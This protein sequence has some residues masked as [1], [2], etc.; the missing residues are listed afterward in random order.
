MQRLTN[1]GGAFRRRTE[2]EVWA[3]IE[4]GSMLIP[5]CGCRIWLGAATKNGYGQVQIN[6]KKIYLHRL[7]YERRKGYIPDGMNVCHTCDIPACINEDHLWLGTFQQNHEDKV[8]KGR[9]RG[10]RMVGEEHL[11]AKLTAEEVLAIR[12]RYARG[13]TQTSLAKEFGVRQGHLT[14]VIARRC[15][16]HI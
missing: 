15:W 13:E 9:A 3:M 14:N 16:R 6:G 1:A 11:Q 5:W 7:V 12:E 8:K 2:A 10:G 4:A